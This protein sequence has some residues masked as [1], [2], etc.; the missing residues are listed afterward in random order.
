MMTKVILP[1]FG[2]SAGV[3]TAS[4]LFYQCLLLLGYLYAHLLARRFPVRTQS[5]IHLAL[6]AISLLLLPA[7]PDPDWKAQ[8]SGDPLPNILGVLGASVGL[9][10]LVLS[11]TSPL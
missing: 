8:P 4:M 10:Y 2:G 9:P 5:V 11:T 3:W 6:L 1:W 7:R